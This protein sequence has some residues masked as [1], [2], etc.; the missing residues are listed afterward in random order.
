MVKSFTL[1]GGDTFTLS[2]G[3]REAGAK[4]QSEARPTSGLQ[5]EWPSW[6]YATL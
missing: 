5:Q 6:R 4:G 3:G 2:E 1:S